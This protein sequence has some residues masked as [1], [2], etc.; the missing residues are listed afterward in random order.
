MKSISE[1]YIPDILMFVLLYFDREFEL[2]NNHG[3]VC[4]FV[5]SC[6]PNDNSISPVVVKHNNPVLSNKRPFSC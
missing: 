6:M 1:L 5:H 2:N 3:D 4:R